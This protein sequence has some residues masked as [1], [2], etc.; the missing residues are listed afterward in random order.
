MPQSVINRV[1]FIGRDQPHQAVFADCSGNVIGNDDPTYD[2]YDPVTLNDDSLGEILPDA[3]PDNVYITGVDTEDI[4]TPESSPVTPVEIPGVDPGDEQQQTVKIN[5]ID[6]SRQQEP[7]LVEPALPAIARRSER[8]RKP[9]ERYVPS[10]SGKTYS[11]TQLGMSFLQDTHYKHSPDIVAAV[12]TQLSL[13]AA[14]RQWGNDAKIAVE[15]EAKQLHWRNSF[16]PVHWKD[17]GEEK[18]EQILESHVFVKKKRL[19]EIKAR[20]VAGGN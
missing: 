18:R 20:K 13:K 11:Y 6:I 2:N 19:G 12:L 3:A 8:Q 10:M 4:V 17:I 1:N 5:D 15:A 7:T 14:L 9:T 16:K